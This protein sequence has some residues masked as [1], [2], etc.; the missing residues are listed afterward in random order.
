MSERSKRIMPLYEEFELDGIEYMCRNTPSYDFGD[1][2][3]RHSML[4][5]SRGGDGMFR[6]SSFYQLK[7]EDAVHDDV[8]CEFCVDATLVE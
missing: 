2:R 7:Q 8:S 3:I 5:P 6:T 4:R 1:A